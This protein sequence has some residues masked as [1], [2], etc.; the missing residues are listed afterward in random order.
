MRGRIVTTQPQSPRYFADALAGRQDITDSYHILGDIPALVGLSTESEDAFVAI[1]RQIIDDD[2]DGTVG[3]DRIAEPLAD[4]AADLYHSNLIAAVDGTDAVSPLRFAS[5]TIYAAGVVLVTPQ[6]HQ[7]P[8]AHVARTRA[9]HLTPSDAPGITWMEALTRWAEYLRGAREQENSWTI[10]FRE[11]EEREIAHEWLQESKNHFVLIDGPILTQNMLSQDRARELLQ[12]IVDDGRA[13]GFI[14]DLSA[15]PLISAIG[16]ALRP[17]EVFVMKEWS[18]IL[19][20]RFGKRQQSI[21]KWIEENAGTIVRAVYKI[22]RKAFAIECL[23]EHVPLG[24]AIL[25]YDNTGSLDHDIP[26]MLQIADNHVRTMF[27]G[28]RARDEVIARFSANDP[29]RFL[30]LTNERSLR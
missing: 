6:T 10:T 20:D 29:D 12:R 8:K 30:T 4:S 14:K 11:Y 7:R 3:L 2:T 23:A 16:Y 9:S 19:S 26:M 17:G 21:S 13:I 24:L 15:N 18:T 5:D 27:N 28:A 22:N 25:K 1:L